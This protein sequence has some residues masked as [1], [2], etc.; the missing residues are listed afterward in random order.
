[1]NV[2][3]RVSLILLI[4][5]TTILAGCAVFDPLPTPGT[6]S[7]DGV[8]AQLC[9]APEFF[10]DSAGGATI[11]EEFAGDAEAA[12]RCLDAW[13]AAY[14]GALKDHYRFRS[15]QE[16]LI[17]ALSAKALYEGISGAG[18]GHH[19]AALGIGSAV[20][21]GNMVRRSPNPKLQVYAAGLKAL[22]CAAIQARPLLMIESERQALTSAINVQS[23]QLGVL[24]GLLARSAYGGSASESEIDARNTLNLMQADLD[25]A[26]Q[27]NT[28]ILHSGEEI[29]SQVGRI[30]DNVTEQLRRTEPDP[31]SITDLIKSYGQ[32]AGTFSHGFLPSVSGAGVSG[33]GDGL[34]GRGD[35]RGETGRET[36]FGPVTC[37]DSLLDADGELRRGETG[38]TSVEAA[39]YCA[40]RGSYA[41][42]IHMTSVA[43]VEKVTAAI[44]GCGKPEDLKPAPSIVLQPDVNRIDL[45][46]RGKYTLTIRSSGGIPAVG[47]YGNAANALEALKIDSSLGYLVVQIS[48]TDKATPSPVVLAVTAPNGDTRQVQIVVSKPAEPAPQPAP[49]TKSQGAASL[50]VRDEESGVIGTAG[51]ILELQCWL[52]IAPSKRAGNMGPLSRARVVIA[53]RQ[54]ALGDTDTVTEKLTDIL[55]NLRSSESCIDKALT[56]DQFTD[57]LKAR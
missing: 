1:M 11:R 21:Y 3:S 48:A 42:R 9:P 27:L 28:R 18:N 30:V 38:P 39:L 24:S 19:I 55:R 20:L 53:N 15:A 29:R 56:E 46:T 41:L 16:L 26:S 54:L 31:S 6:R 12:I 17:G 37:S 45:K 23:A 14:Y 34:T 49:T 44:E 57:A 22:S 52:G 2:Q 13:R 47:F 5:L 32:L 8:Q 7:R 43:Q 4:A 10:R 33:S 35:T 36:T 51:R 40:H 50:G 25:R